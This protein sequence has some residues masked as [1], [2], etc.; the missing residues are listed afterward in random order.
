MSVQTDDDVYLA[1]RDALFGLAYRMLG[2]ISDAEDVVAESYLRWRRS[3]RDNVDNPRAF[4]FSIASRLSLD[5]LTSA[6]RSRVDYVGNWLPEPLLASYDDPAAAAETTDTISL[7]FLH[8]L[9]QLTPQE[10]AVFVL[11]NA[12]DYPHAEIAGLLDMSADNVRQLHRRA[13]LRLGAGAAPR[14][15]PDT[16]RGRE[17]AQRFLAAAATGEVQP[18]AELLAEDVVLVGD[19]GG[20]AASVRRPISGRLKIARFVRRLGLLSPPGTRFDVVLAN[21]A[22]A[23][24]VVTPEAIEGVYA[25]D[26]DPVTELVIGIHAVRNPDKLGRVRR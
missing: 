3:N 2:S 1:H 20:K 4:L 23:L 24:L 14:F 7:A 16:A 10:R 8:L 17:L 12:F 26:F 21:G 15:V 18:L 6:Q 25:I 5:L 13:Q 19:G 22:P 9:E 11:R